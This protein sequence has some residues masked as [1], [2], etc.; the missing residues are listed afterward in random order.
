LSAALDVAG[1]VFLARFEKGSWKYLS[2]EDL[3]IPSGTI[4]ASNR[5]GGDSA[6]LA[7]E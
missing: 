6:S 4:P 7:G 1:K 3:E 5:I 2:R